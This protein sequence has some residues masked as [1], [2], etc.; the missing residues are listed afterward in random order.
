MRR[1]VLA[2]VIALSIG[3]IAAAIVLDREYER[4]RAASTPGATASA[5]ATPTPGT[6]GDARTIDFADPALVGPIIDHFKGGAIPKERLRALPYAA[7]CVKCKSG[8]LGL[9]R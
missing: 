3:G 2:A 9:G 6:P 8:G 7:L 5:S 4:S 1:I